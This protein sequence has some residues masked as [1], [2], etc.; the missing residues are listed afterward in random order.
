MIS[1]ACVG[2]LRGARAAARALA[3]HRRGAIRTL[4]LVGCV[5]LAKAVLQGWPGKGKESVGALAAELRAGNSVFDRIRQAVWHLVPPRLERALRLLKPT[6]DQ[7]F[8]DRRLRAAAQLGLRGPAASNAVPA[9]LRALRHEEFGDDQVIDEELLALGRIGPAARPAVPDLLRWLNGQLPAAPA[10]PSLRKVVTRVRYGGT[11]P[12]SVSRTARPAK[13]GTW[14]RGAAWALARIAP[15]DPQVRSELLKALGRCGVGD[16]DACIRP[17]NFNEP[18]LEGWRPAT[19]GAT[20]GPMSPSEKRNLLRAIGRLR[21]QTPETLAALL[22]QLDHGEYAAQATAADVVGQMRP[23]CREGVAKLIA[24]LTRTG[25]E[26]LPDNREL[27]A[28]ATAWWKAYERHF[29]SVP[30]SVKDTPEKRITG[31]WGGGQRGLGEM[32]DTVFVQV[33]GFPGWGLRLRIIRALGQLGPAAREAMPLLLSEC[34]NPTTVLR[35]DAAVAAWRI[36]G[37]SPEVIATFE[38][39]WRCADAQT[40]QLET[41]R[42]KELAAESPQAVAPLMEG[43][44]DP[45]RAIRLQV[46][47]SL[48]SLGVKAAPAL[49]ALRALEDDPEPIVRIGATQALR[50]V[51]FPKAAETNSVVRPNR[52]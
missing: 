29:G 31:A 13:P 46:M 39:G 26:H 47:A 22:D 33:P 45:S 35:F 49:P 37:A 48:A 12:V 11:L 20:G 34:R 30:A 9:L 25:G 32:V 19:W 27:D 2:L 23:V 7:T 5:V 17:D 51:Q 21:P 44:S 18:V 52:A 41:A 43:L 1:T 14:T 40:R 16:L 24:G 42:L 38:D 10:P 15:D 6:E 4:V 3:R 50:A 28:L 8:H 36:H